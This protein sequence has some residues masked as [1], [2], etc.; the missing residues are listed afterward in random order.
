MKTCAEESD[1][2]EL[3]LGKGV[4]ISWQKIIDV[5]VIYIQMSNNQ[6]DDLPIYKFSVRVTFPYQLTDINIQ[7]QEGIQLK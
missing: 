2:I 1:D 4:L 3:L 5:R 7:Q 6:I